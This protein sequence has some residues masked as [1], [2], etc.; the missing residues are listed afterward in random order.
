MLTNALLSIDLYR[1]NIHFTTPRNAKTS[2]LMGGI[3]SLLIYL[4]SIAI[5][6]IYIIELITSSS[7][8]I[9]FIESSYINPPSLLLSKD[10]LSF[11]FGVLH[12]DAFQFKI[13]YKDGTYSNE[14][15]IKQCR[16]SD[17]Q[18]VSL[19]EANSDLISR[20][21]CPAGNY[22]YVLSGGLIENS[23]S[24]LSIDIIAKESISLNSNIILQLL[25][26]TTAY[27]LNN[28][29]DTISY[30]MS[31]DEF[32]LNSSS[33][34]T[35]NC[36]LS[37]QT[38]NKNTNIL[39][40]HH[41]TSTSITIDTISV[42]ASLLATNNIIATINFISS[43]KYF[44]YEIRSIKLLETMSLIGGNIYLLTIIGKTIAFIFTMTNH[45]LQILNSVF[46]FSSLKESNNLLLI[47]KIKL[48]DE[49][50]KNAHFKEAK[51]NDSRG[52]EKYVL[53][54]SDIFPSLNFATDNMFIN[55]N[56]HNDT[57]TNE[58]SIHKKAKPNKTMISIDDNI[59]L[60]L[61]KMIAFKRARELSQKKLLSL[62]SFEVVQL[63]CCCHFNRLFTYKK[64]LYK[65]KIKEING[66]MDLGYFFDKCMS[67]EK[68]QTVL[69]KKGHHG[70]LSLLTREMIDKSN[71][72]KPLSVLIND[73]V[74]F[75]NTISHYINKLKQPNYSLTHLDKKVL[76]LLNV[77]SV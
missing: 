9:S 18:N 6:L 4:S 22:S 3:I 29:S 21:T 74:A 69:L 8:F 63:Y 34:T 5:A 65:D 46:D 39:N 48:G 11:G 75:D 14:I 43:T 68:I 30:G 27:D 54:T 31:I 35:I 61:K 56:N 57:N 62:S 17:F 36:L 45:N 47:P 32:T 20:M 40:T 12:S 13:N 64:Q 52:K 38:L 49:F 24:I 25:F 76:K 23:K 42:E 67:I 70:I 1:K 53:K 66:L 55:L 10:T 2:T 33:K 51:S 77:V 26:G 71:F 60:K 73:Q 72:N 28:K 15:P 41:R 50:L 7:P 37:Y 59:E 58:N 16:Q 44:I 19:T